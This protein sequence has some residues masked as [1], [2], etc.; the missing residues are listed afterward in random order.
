MKKLKATVD[1]TQSKLSVK[2]T[3]EKN[4]SQSKREIAVLDVFEIEPPE[5]QNVTMRTSSQ[6]KL[7]HVQESGRQ[8]TVDDNKAVLSHVQESR[9][10]TNVDDNKDESSHVQESRR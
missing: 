3:T 10:Q 4:R 2:V 6:G 1:T 9:R 7:S 5:P 8:T